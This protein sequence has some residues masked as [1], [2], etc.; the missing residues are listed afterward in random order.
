[1]GSGLKVKRFKLSIRGKGRGGSRKEGGG[2][3][4]YFIREQRKVRD[5]KH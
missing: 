3:T 5:P 1:M 4:K 2:V